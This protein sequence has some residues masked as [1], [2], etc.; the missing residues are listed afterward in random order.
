MKISAG[1]LA[2]FIIA[3]IMG[4]IALAI[5]ALLIFFPADKIKNLVAS[6]GSKILGRT[7]TIDKVQFSLFPFIGAT[8]KGLEVDGTSRESFTKDKFVTLEKIQV[9]IAVMSLF[10]KKPEITKIILDKPHILI[11]IDTAGH[12]SF[13]DLAV[14]Q[15]SDTLK[16][17]KKSSGPLVLPVPVTLQKFAINN[18]VIIYRDMKSKQEFSVNDLDQSIQFS[19]DKELKDIRTSGELV[20]GSV[21]VKTKEIVKPLKNLKISLTHDLAADLVNGTATVNQLRLSFQKLFFN[22]KGNV[23]NLNATPLVDLHLESDA[24]QIN[25]ILQEIPVE[26]APDVAKLTASGVAAITLAIKG[27]VRDSVPLPING[28]CKLDNVNIKYTALSKSVN[29]LNALCDFTDTSVSISTMKFN[30]GENPVELHASFINFKNPYVDLG[31]LAKLNLTD[32]RDIFVLPPGAALAGTANIDINA[33]GRPDPNDPSKL[34]LKGL[35]NFGDLSVLWPPLVKPAVIKGDVTLSS[36]AIGQN[37]DVTIGGSALKLN[38]TMK[39]YLSMVFPVK[40]KTLP[41]PY[42]EFTLAASMLNIDEFWPQSKDTSSAAP[43]AAGSADAPLLA[44][45]PGIDMKAV[46][47]STRCIYQGITLDNLN[48]SVN[49]IN[50]IANINVRTGFSGGTITNVLNGDL[51]DVNDIKFTNAFNVEKVQVSD[52]I[53]K[54]APFIKPVNVLNRELVNLQNSL[55]GRLSLQSTFNGRGRS[56]ADIMKTLLGDVSLRV[57]DGQITK[58]DMVASLA[59]KVEKFVDIKDIQFRDMKA[60]IHVENER[61]NFED[62]K[63]GSTAGDWDIK[64]S[65]G[66]DGVLQMAVNNRLTKELSDKVNALQNKGRDAAKN[67]LAGTKFAAASQLID[68]VGIPSDREGR[69]TLKM[70]LGGT[71]E[72]PEASF[73]GFGEGVGK[74]AEQQ[75]PSQQVKQQVQQVIEEKKEQLK[76]AIDEEKAK[77]EDAARKKLEEEKAALE[78]QAKQK[79]EQLKNEGL[80]KLKKIF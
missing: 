2:L 45:L 79:Q 38:G 7:V 65:T 4:V 73:A 15:S 8:I 67:L 74:P 30:L 18:G 72:K 37:L 32:F 14:M 46:I 47:K 55:S 16:K 26:L 27:E 23:T 49:V 10:N 76:N 33:K 1:K 19:I 43:G 53:S 36:I 24:L 31:I 40:G 28:T 50:D 70:L 3:G 34:D 42:T 17:E 48:M 29:N 13:D 78:E 11:E 22:L 9:Q 57:G 61:L 25:D 54:F 20:L 52:L 77:V 69:I 64:G 51:R 58:S 63:I 41:R 5:G 39:N 44:P 66:F 12:F 80:K 35:V 21:S 59:S 71:I 75:T 68:N 62:F 56:Q 60:A 6:E